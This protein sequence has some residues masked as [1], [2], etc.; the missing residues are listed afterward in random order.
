MHYYAI[1]MHSA[2]V[3]V[4]MYTLCGYTR[5]L[6]T[7]RNAA[8][9]VNRSSGISQAAAIAIHRPQGVIVLL[10]L[11]NTIPSLPSKVPTGTP[12]WRD[13]KVYT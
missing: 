9:Q 4:H 2:C 5:Q 11:S 8:I 13:E 10:S 1:F 12:Y 3:H 7:C 6:R